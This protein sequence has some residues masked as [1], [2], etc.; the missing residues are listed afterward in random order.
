MSPQIPPPPKLGKA[1]GA[2]HVDDGNSS[3]P[4]RDL[5]KGKTSKKSTKI[6]KFVM[7][8]PSQ[9]F[10]HDFDSG[11]VGQ[12][13]SEGAHEAEGGPPGARQ[14]EVVAVTPWPGAQTS[15]LRGARKS[16]LRYWCWLN[17]GVSPNLNPSPLLLFGLGSTVRTFLRKVSKSKSLIKSLAL[18]EFVPKYSPNCPPEVMVRMPWAQIT[19]RESGGNVILNV[20]QTRKTFKTT[21]IK[22]QNFVISPKTE[23]IKCL[24]NVPMSH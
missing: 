20:A 5:N 1:M 22:I 11:G 7:P 10:I 6:E 21:L 14:K 15:S 24:C 4:K 13:R 2:N 19:G 18:L 23:V 9:V 3:F 17:Q 12:W 8:T 16:S